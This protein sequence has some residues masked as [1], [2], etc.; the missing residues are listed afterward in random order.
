MQMAMLYGIGPNL[1]GGTRDLARYERWRPLY[2]KYM[3]TIIALCQAGWEPVTYA[4]AE[5]DTI[6][7]E[8]F[9]PTHGRLY[10]TARNESSRGVTV[11]VTV[12]TASLHIAAPTRVKRLPG[13]RGIA[14]E[15]GRFQDTLEPGVTCA[16]QVLH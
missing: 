7:L 1:V 15:D 14:F 11:T 16:Y 2:R 9:G 10:L 12:Q 6:L 5:P 3:P 8:R 13:G 4:S